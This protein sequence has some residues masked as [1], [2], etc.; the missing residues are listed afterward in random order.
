MLEYEYLFL[1][2]M[3]KTLLLI[4]DGWGTGPDTEHNA[5]AQA[6]PT[7]WQ[8]LLSTYP[9]NQLSAK[10]AS[11]GL[12]PGL[13][14]NSE[15]GH[16]TIGA[17]RV[18]PQSAFAIAESI[19]NGSF[20]KNPVLAQISDH[21]S[22]HNSTLHF[23]GMLSTGGVHAHL[24]HLFALI[25]WAQNQHI[26]RVALHL[27][28][29]GRDMAP[30]SALPLLQEVERSLPPSYRIA[31][32]IGRAIAMDRAEQWERTVETVHTLTSSEPTTTH[33]PEAY[34]HSNYDIG[35]GDEFMPPARFST[36]AISDNDAVLCFNFRADRMRQLGKIL[37]RTAP[38]T[39]QDTVTVPNNLFLAS[40]TG[41]DETFTDIHVLF[42]KTNTKNN[43][44][45]WISA[46]GGKQL[47]LAETEKYAH[48]TYFVNGGEEVKYPHEERL[49]IP[50]LGLKNYAERPEMSLP[51]LTDTLVRALEHA[52]FDLVICNIANGDMVG[53]SGNFEAAIH[54]VQH[55][56]TALARIIPK[57]TAHGYTTLITADH[58]NIESMIHDGAPHTAHTFNTVPCVITRNDIILRDGHLHEVAPTIL[59]LM[60]L[61]KPPEM[62]STSLLK[63]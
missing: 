53:H 60:G 16:I 58:G 54:A 14:S 27:F 22:I 12:L 21:V 30:Q 63:P 55:V 23:I 57:A 37:L 6:K 36:E 5:I 32:L 48:V 11:V 15:V 18:V 25:A 62:T 45:E 59:D 49:M 8:H 35:V 43:L 46:Q 61:P 29:D 44:G 9:H 10:E 56:D 13:L 51:E 50:S 3:K 20:E 28:L 42:P 41:Y 47:R 39:V 31:T 17:G 26:P 34:I 2:H 7:Y 40:M 33:T 24:S 38:H 1:Y 19:T 52:H 4:L